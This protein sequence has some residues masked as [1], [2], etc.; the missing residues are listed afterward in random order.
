MRTY[1][2]FA[3]F[4]WIFLV[5]SLAVGFSGETAL[6]VSYV[7]VDGQSFLEVQVPDTVDVTADYAQAG[8]RLIAEIYLDLNGNGVVDG[9]ETI[10]QFAY[11]NDGIP[12]LE[13]AEGDE[14]P[15]DDDGQVNGLLLHHLELLK[16]DY[17]FSTVPM[18]FLVKITD[19][20]HSVAQ[21]ILRVTPP[22]PG[23]PYI[24]GTVTDAGTAAPLDSMVVIAYE[25][26][27][28]DQRASLTDE[29]GRYE[30]DV[31]AGDWIVYAWDLGNYYAPADSQMISVL[32]LDSAVVDF[33]L[34]P[35]PA[36][37]TG[38]VDSSGGNPVPGI[39]MVAM[40][41]EDMSVGWTQADGF[42]RIGVSPGT[43]TICPFFLPQ[44]YASIPASYTGVVVDHGATVEGKNFSLG[45][46]TS[47]I[48]GTVTFQAGGGASGVTVSAF[49]IA[50]Y[51]YSAT[52]DADGSYSLA[53]LPAQ[54]MI[55][56]HLEGY[57]VV[58]PPNQAYLFVNVSSDSTVT[59]KD[60]IIEP[61]GGGPISIS[62]TVTYQA[63]GDPAPGV[64]VVIYNDEQD[65]PLGWS[66]AETNASG[67][68]E[69]GDISLGT[70]LIGAYEGGYAS[71]PS[72]REQTF[73]W[74]SPPATDQDFQLVVATGVTEGL[75]VAVPGGFCLFQNR[76]NPFND[77]T[78]IA[79]TLSN[80][81]AER[82]TLSIFNVLGQEIRTLVDQQQSAGFHLVHWDGRDHR[83]LPVTSGIYFCQLQAGGARQTS[84]LVLLR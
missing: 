26:T 10:V 28:D 42:Y 76:P 79:Y 21:A 37:I 33:A 44:G 7:Y 3:A 24:G 22:T 72:L 61:S 15:G 14:I 32:A 34:S 20:D 31:E 17:S 11:I 70:W 60:F 36:Y 12:T 39:M 62:G 30:L 49:C 5:I 84:K 57:D 53:V 48:E 63:G 83:G 64:Y 8:N 2:K 51:H 9:Q 25:T 69:F 16:E 55:T 50:G 18:Q 1:R 6:A 66:F 23:R 13:N 52:T 71:D 29:Q 59:D 45:H 68:Y 58:Y 77:V 74:G 27:L 73:S 4:L 67:Y 56:A 40:E 54:Y 35:F 65:S 47:H 81:Q 80:A 82:V 75:E 19:Q 78:I 41:E 43:Y 46:P 38:T